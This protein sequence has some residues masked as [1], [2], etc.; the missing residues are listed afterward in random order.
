MMT[1]NVS[2]QL[3]RKELDWFGG[4]EKNAGRMNP[5]E[6]FTYDCLGMG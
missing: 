2:D 4:F 3:G 6:L 5:G 1:V